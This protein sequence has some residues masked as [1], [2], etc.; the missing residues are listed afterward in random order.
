MDPRYKELLEINREIEDALSTTIKIGYEQVLQIVVADL[1]SKYKAAVKRK[2]EKW[3]P[4]F[5]Q[6]L[7]FYLEDEELEALISGFEA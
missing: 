5:K 4:V 6:A 3:E 2:D 1:L 7:R